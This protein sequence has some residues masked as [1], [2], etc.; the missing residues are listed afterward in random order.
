MDL[1]NSLKTSG[2]FRILY[3]FLAVLFSMLYIFIISGIV[4]KFRFWHWV[5]FECGLIDFC[6]PWNG[7][8]MISVRMGVGPFARICLVFNAKFGDVPLEIV[9]LVL[10]A[11]FSAGV[12]FYFTPWRREGTCAC[13]GARN[14]T[15][16]EILRTYQMDCPLV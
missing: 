3:K 6:F 9:H 5:G 15:F 16:G 10:Y 14:V 13:Q 12:T 7:F 1:K 11:K 2:C 8:L 4:T